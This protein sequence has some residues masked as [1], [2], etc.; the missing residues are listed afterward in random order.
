MASFLTINGID[1]PT[2]VDG[3]EAEVEQIAD[4]ARAE[5]QALIENLEAVKLHLRLKLQPQT[6]A[7][8]FAFRQLIN[9]AGHYWSFDDTAG[10]GGTAGLYSSGGLGPTGAI[11]GVTLGTSAPAP[12]RGA[13]RVQIT[14]G[15]SLVYTLEP[16]LP[17][18][19]VMV[20][21]SVNGGAWNHYFKND[22]GTI[23][24]N[25]VL[26]GA[27]SP[28]PQIT[29]NLAAGTVT[30]N[31]TGGVSYQF[32]ELV[33]FPYRLP[34]SWHAQAYTQQ[35][36]AGSNKSW[37]ALRQLLVEGDVLPEGGS[38]TMLGRVGREGIR[39]WENLGGVAEQAGREPEFEL[40]E[41]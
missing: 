21:Q 3:A 27:P 31:T 32:D 7:N 5:N 34:A 39:Q 25:G 1:V 38:K 26:N 24:Q 2:L 33:I 17:G 4:S 41:V 13:G 11:T 37:S 19:E 18:I 15:N 23:Y 12:W 9:G 28:V 20:A 10:G 40:L 30:L 35:N 8:G 6:R 29:I 14:S 16:N 22:G 36:P